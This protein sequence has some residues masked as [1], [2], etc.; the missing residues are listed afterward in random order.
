MVIQLLAIQ[1]FA[2]AQ[3]INK[4]RTISVLFM[5]FSGANTMEAARLGSAIRM[6][7]EW[8]S[9][10]SGYTIRPSINTLK[11][12]PSRDRLSLADRIHNPKYLINGVISRE[13]GVSVV[14]ISLWTLEDHPA[15]I[16]SETFDYRRFDDALSMVP[17]YSWSLYAILPVLDVI[18]EQLRAAREVVEAAIAE[19][20][21]ARVD[22]D[23]A[24]SIA[25]STW[26]ELAKAQA[27][28]AAG[29]NA[30]AVK[31]SPSKENKESPVVVSVDAATQAWQSRR[32]YLGLRAGISPRFYNFEFDLPKDLGF[33]W[34]AAFQ[35]EFQFLRF[36]WGQ[37]NVFLGV[38][39][40]VIFTM[41]KFNLPDVEGNQS[42]KACLSIMT[43]LLLK[44]NYKPGP[45]TLSLYGG[46]YYLAYLSSSAENSTP[47]GY[48]L[49]FKFGVKAGKRGTVFFDLRYSSDLGLTSIESSLP[50]SYRRY[51]PTLALGYEVGLFDWK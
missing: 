12:P 40:E 47:W 22:A 48:G 6:E 25:N 41:D 5:T 43:P 10:E 49:G 38:Q 42:D 33:T 1:A 50:V 16:F 20:K 37:R 8:M 36:P 14:D 26:E 35:V 17:F 45:F 15:L 32:L 51:I 46:M 30:N 24:R 39:G 29:A 13:G 31:N 3:T 19:A 7:L 34:E 11:M 2:S 9:R 21:T 27:I 44:V 18:P 28:I 4:E 23:V